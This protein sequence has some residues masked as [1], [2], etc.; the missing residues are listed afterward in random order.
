MPVGICRNTGASVFA[1]AAGVAL[2]GALG[3]A[4][5]GALGGATGA[6]CGAA[7]GAALGGT[8]GGAVGLVTVEDCEDRDRGR[9]TTG[10]GVFALGVWFQL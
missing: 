2:D 5:G 9:G 6:A 4:T 10:G 8:T 7:L 1:G 3:G